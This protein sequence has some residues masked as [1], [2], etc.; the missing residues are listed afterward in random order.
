MRLDHLR[1]L[2]EEGWVTYDLLA[3]LHSLIQHRT[4]IGFVLGGT[5]KLAEDFWSLLYSAADS[6]ELGPLTKSQTEQL[7]REPAQPQVNFDDLVVERIWR[8]TGGHPLPDAAWFATGCWRIL[9]R[10]ISSE[11]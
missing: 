6:R 7:I 4:R 5:N 8:L 11:R 3:Y 2:I 9:M 10:T 1:F